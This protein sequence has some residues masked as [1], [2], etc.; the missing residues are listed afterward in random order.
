MKKALAEP[1][2]AEAECCNRVLADGAAKLLTIH[3]RWP[4]LEETSPGAQRINRYYDAL[5]DR[6]LKRWEGPLLTQARAAL[7]TG[8]AGA[9]QLPWSAELDFTITCFHDGVLS[10]YIDAAE[11]VGARRPRRVRQGDVWLLPSG[12]P[13]TLRELLPRQRRWWRLPVLE[14]VRRQAGRQLQAGEAVFYDDWVK[15]ISKRFSPGRFYLTEAGPVVFYPV[16]SIAPAME[17]FP[18]FPLS[19]LLA[20]EESS[21]HSQAVQA[22]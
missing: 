21:P 16:E 5:A 7:T 14:T 2:L 22:S 15:L 10:L 12:I 18:T 20:Q 13:L 6:W 9:N 11:N 19:E 1:K 4:R 8:E 17:G 3:A